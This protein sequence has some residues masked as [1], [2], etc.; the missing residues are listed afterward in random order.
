MSDKCI[1]C[2]GSGYMSAAKNMP[3]DT[4]S[5]LMPV[6]C[7]PCSGCHGTGKANI[8]FSEEDIEKLEKLLKDKQEK[9]DD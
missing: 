5:V 3:I 6:G 7:W 8:L 1:L 4:P 9:K 2:G